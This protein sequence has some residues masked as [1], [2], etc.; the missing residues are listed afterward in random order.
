MIRS[1]KSAG[2]RRGLSSAEF[3]SRDPT[4]V[5]KTALVSSLQNA[6]HLVNPVSQLSKLSPP[7]TAV[8][9]SSPP[10]SSEWKNAPIP[11]ELISPLKHE[12]IRSYAR[13]QHE[14]TP[15]GCRHLTT[16]QL[17]YTLSPAMNVVKRASTQFR[18]S[19]SA[20]SS[21]IGSR[22][23]LAPFSSTTIS[24]LRSV[25]WLAPLC[26][27]HGIRSFSTA[28]TQVTSPPIDANNN[29]P[30]STPPTT[31][32]PKPAT[33]STPSPGGKGAE[34]SGDKHTNSQNHENPPPSKKMSPALKLFLGLT[35]LAGSVLGGLLVADA[36]LDGGLLRSLERWRKKD[37]HVIMPLIP[38]PE[39]EFNHPLN[40]EPAWYQAW[41]RI[42]RY[43]YLAY[44]F[45]P[46]VIYHFWTSFKGTEQSR[47]DFLEY[48]VTRLEMAGCSFLKFGQWLSMRPDMFPPDVIA[49]LA[50]LRDKA[51]S[52][53]FEDTRRAIKEQLGEDID[54][55]FERFDTTPVASGS[56]AQVYRARLTEEW[57]NKAG[58]LDK[59]G[60]IVRDVA[61][62][63]RHPQVLHETWMD[64]DMIFA[65]VTN[66]KVM[67][68]PFS[69]EEFLAL[70]QKQID[71]RW[72]G[73]YLTR[74]AHNFEAET[75]DGRLKFPS[76]SNSLLAQGVLVESWADG[77][78]VS[79]IFTKVGEGF[80]TSSGVSAMAVAAKAAA[81]AGAGDMGRHST[82]IPSP[83]DHIHSALANIKR[84]FLS[85]EAKILSWTAA[86]L[87]DPSSRDEI[88]HR[89]READDAALLAAYEADPE[90]F[91]AMTKDGKFDLDLMRK[92]QQIALTMFDMFLK[93]FLRDNLIHGD[94]HAGNVLYND[95]DNASTIL[96]AGMAV[97]LE[98]EVMSSFGQFLKALCSGDASGLV[99]RIEQFEVN[100]PEF[101]KGSG[102][103]YLSTDPKVKDAFAQDINQVITKFF[104]PSASKAPMQRSNVD[105]QVNGDGTVISPRSHIADTAT[106]AATAVSAA[107]TE[108]AKKI[109][110][111][112]EPVVQSVTNT[113][114]V[115]NA[116]VAVGEASRNVQ[117][118]VDLIQH[119]D[120]H[121]S[122][123]DVVGQVLFCMQRHKVVLRGDVAASIMAMSVCEGLIRQ[124]DPTLDIVMKS[125]PYFIRYKG[126]TTVQS[127]L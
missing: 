51:P 24:A 95:K 93:M 12:T 53:P 66:S 41:F 3:G 98:P 69:K 50:Q 10:C 103:G 124:L 11:P 7:Q 104:G 119:H 39:E 113:A 9:L 43:F 52:H 70:M 83:M 90:L 36:V 54:V 73:H 121:V 89:Q 110:S 108:S 47:A 116:V 37:V 115:G 8:T 20:P 87:K 80:N 14:S 48:L 88:Y 21:S 1:L 22:P 2:F 34:G 33:D 56:I 125:L 55:I 5:T 46:V 25:A 102:K 117:D 13:L 85:V 68:V 62:K 4:F 57:A 35:V 27:H 127:I 77:E 61:V 105:A 28:T 58:L 114:V 15:A 19:A 120:N 94:L 109:R 18:S 84:H 72:E 42:T 30:T 74:F 17:A 97:S 31:L 44:L 118:A 32:D 45:I 122:I 123:G 111:A 76:V 75:R 71:F 99:N 126:Y 112:V 67:T 38:P 64:V 107:G 106:R 29:K 16:A 59:N 6:S 96:D 40:E 26:I 81:K 23:S 78:S 82:W 63:V 92:K 79:A 101:G 91:Q 65:F 100:R 60:Q 49:A 86:L